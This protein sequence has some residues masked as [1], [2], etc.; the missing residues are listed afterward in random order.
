MLYSKL[1]NF[2]TDHCTLH[3]PK[4]GLT[5]MQKYS[6]ADILLYRTRDL[7][8]GIRATFRKGTLPPPSPPQ[9]F[10]KLT[11]YM[12]YMYTFT[13]LHVVPTWNYLSS[14]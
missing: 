6:T 4:L 13:P 11:V 8:K 5:L 9:T 2:H 12:L 7:L 3:S 1:R 14:T 10:G